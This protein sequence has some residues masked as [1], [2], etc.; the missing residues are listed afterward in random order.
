MFVL[1]YRCQL[2]P[3]PRY[4]VSYNIETTQH[5]NQ[6]YEWNPLVD[7]FISLGTPTDN[8]KQTSDFLSYLLILLTNWSIEGCL[9]LYPL[10][11]TAPTFTYETE[12][13]QLLTILNSSS[14]NIK[15][16]RIEDAELWNFSETNFSVNR[17]IVE[18]KTI[19][20]FHLTWI[21]SFFGCDLLMLC[22]YWCSCALLHHIC[23]T[24][25]TRAC[26]SVV[27]LFTICDFIL[28]F[29]KC[30]SRGVIGGR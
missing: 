9:C 14:L 8:T 11:R 10:W 6:W 22:S 29:S 26:V 16:P 30:W 7:N 18:R 20:P 21:S 1:N 5:I 15:L 23:I 27:H 4:L 19:F 24:I 28:S 25:N 3:F 2:N 12:R 17:S 13:I